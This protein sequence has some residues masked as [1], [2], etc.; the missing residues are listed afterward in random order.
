MIEEIQAEVDKRWEDLL[1]KCGES[2]NDNSDYIGHSTISINKGT[3]TPNLNLHVKCF[4]R[5][6]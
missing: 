5:N 3:F 1:K 2:S 6:V 4:S